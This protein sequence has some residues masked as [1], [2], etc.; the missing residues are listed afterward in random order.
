MR[1][2]KIKLSVRKK[3][4]LDPPLDLD[5]CSWM[6][7]KMSSIQYIAFFFLLSMEARA[8]S[9]KVTVSHYMTNFINMDEIVGA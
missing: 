1:L 4:S 5:T 6:I 8:K 9:D 7:I 2:D 3:V